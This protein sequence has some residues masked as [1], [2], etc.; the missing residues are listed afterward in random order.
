MGCLYLI[1]SPSGMRYIGIGATTAASRW[2]SHVDAARRNGRTREPGA[3]A[4]AIRQYGPEA[5]SV[6]TL[7]YAH[8]WNYLQYLETAAIQAYR[9]RAPRGYNMTAG[10]DTV[11]RLKY[12][13]EQASSVTELGSG[14][15]S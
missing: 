2:V 4:K 5:F 7:V 1:A 15:L 9:T 6:R 13:P 11:P 12:S 8:D 10:G 14:S 3:L